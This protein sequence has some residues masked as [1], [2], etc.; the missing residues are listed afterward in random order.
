MMVNRVGAS[1]M[2]MGDFKIGVVTFILRS[3]LDFEKL[4]NSHKVYVFL[5]DALRYGTTIKPSTA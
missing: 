5:G 3:L 1:I 4:S 2:F